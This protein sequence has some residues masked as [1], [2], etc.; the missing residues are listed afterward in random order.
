M[1]SK[2]AGDSTTPGA[3]LRSIREQ[4]EGVQLKTN[5]AQPRQ[6]VISG[7]PEALKKANVLIDSM[8]AKMLERCADVF[9][10]LVIIFSSLLLI[11]F[12]NFFIVGGICQSKVSR[13]VN[14]PWWRHA[15]EVS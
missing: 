7:P 15:K 1:L 12:L 14:R 10:L 8:C 6:L 11:Y 5:P 3:R 2:Q 4:C 9:F 13:P